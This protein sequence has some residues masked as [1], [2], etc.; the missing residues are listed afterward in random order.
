MIFMAMRFLSTSGRIACD[1]E[2]VVLC[3]HISTIWCR[4]RQARWFRF[5]RSCRASTIIRGRS[6]PLCAGRES[7]WPRIHASNAFICSIV[8]HA[9]GSIGSRW[10]TI[11]PYFGHDD[12][13]KVCRYRA[14]AHF[15]E[16]KPAHFFEKR[17]GLDLHTFGVTCAGF[18][19]KCA[20]K[21][22]HFFEGQCALRPWN[23]WVFGVPAHFRAFFL[24][25]YL[26]E[27]KKRVIIHKKRW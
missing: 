16:L 27:K 23:H 17:A 7:G 24:F 11:W 5:G 19:Q 13:T 26:F 6:R 8:G 1:A 9:E 25:P 20:E 2:N 4:F 14:T 18:A 22:A 3:G 21:P 10:H 12:K 15:L